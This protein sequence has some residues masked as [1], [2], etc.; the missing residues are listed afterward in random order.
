MKIKST[1]I[2]IL[3]LF[4]LYIKGQ[5][6]LLFH[7][8]FDQPSGPDSVTTITIS[9]TNP[10]LWN[11][12][13]FLFSSP[14]R[15]YHVKGS[16]NSSQVVFQTSAF[17]TI[18]Q[19][20][21]YLKF[22]HIAKLFAV[23]KGR[24]SISVDSG[25]TWTNLTPTNY[26]G[27][28]LFPYH[29]Y[30]SA[31]SYGG[32]NYGDPWN[33][34]VYSGAGSIPN[35]SWWREE[36]FDIT[37]KAL[38]WTN[39]GYPDVMIRFTA[40]F[41]LPE[42]T[43]NSYQ[44]GWYIDDL[45][46]TGSQCELIPPTI[47]Q[48]PHLNCWI[49]PL[50]G[51]YVSAHSFS[52]A[53]KFNATDNHQIDSLRLVEIINGV[54]RF[55]SLSYYS[56]FNY[57]ANFSGYSAFDTVKYRVE[58]YD[59]CGNV[60][61]FPDTGYY[62]F[63]FGE[64]FPK[65]VGGNCGTNHNFINSFPWTQDFEDSVWI[66]SSATPWT[67]RGDFPNYLSYEVVPVEF[68]SFGWS[69]ISG[70][71]PILESGPASDHTTGS[72]KYLYSNFSGQTSASNTTFVLP[73][74]DVRD[75]V[76]RY[77]SF[78]YHMYG[79]DIR[80]IIVQIDSTT[81][82]YQNWHRVWDRFYQQQPSEYAPWKK[83]VVDL[84]PYQGKMIK[85]K[86]IAIIDVNNQNRGNIAIDDLFIGDLPNQDIATTTLLNPNLESI[87]CYG[88]NG[89]VVKGNFVN[90]SQAPIS[91]IPVAY[92]LDNNPA[93]Y[94][95]IDFS[96]V[97]VG[98]DTNFAFNTPLNISPTVSHTL[99][100]W[101]DL[102]GDVNNSN[103]T[104]TLEIPIQKYFSIN[105]FPHFL[106]FEGDTAAFD[107]PGVLNS[108]HWSLS[109]TD[110]NIFW[111][112]NHG[113]FLNDP[114][115]PLNISGRND[116][117]LVFRGKQNI[118]ALQYVELLSQCVD[119]TG[120]VNPVLQFQYHNASTSN[121]IEVLVKEPEDGVWTSLN[122]YPSPTS[123]KTNSTGIS[124]NL[125][126][127]TGKIV[128][129]KI[130]V[131]NN[132]ATYSVAMLD[133][134]IIRESPTVDLELTKAGLTSIEEGATSIP[135]I[136]CFITN[137]SKNNSSSLSTVLKMELRKTCDTGNT[138]I[139][140]Q[141]L[142]AT[143]LP[144]G[145]NVNVQMANMTLST[146]MIPGNYSAKFWLETASDSF[147]YNDTIYKD[148]VCLGKIELPYYN[149]FEDCFADVNAYGKY[150]QWQVA[151]PSKAIID[152][153]YEGN[154]CMITNAEMNLITPNG[155]YNYFELPPFDG[156]DTL[157]GVKLSFWQNFD[158]A[159]YQGFGSVEIY[160]GQNWQ[161]LSNGKAYGTNWKSYIAPTPAGNSQ[162]PYGFVG[163]SN[164]WIH[165][166]YPLHEFMS[167]GKKTIRFVCSANDAEGWAIDSIA[168][169]RP[170][171][172]S[173]SPQEV[174]A[175][176]NVISQGSNNVQIKVKN[177]ARAPLH[178]V[179]ITIE[180]NGNLIHNEVINL[181]SPILAGKSAILP[182]SQP[183]VLNPSM[184]E[185]LVYTSN[186]NSRKDE[187]KTDDTLLVPMHLLAETDSLPVCY[188]F[189]QNIDFVPFN[190]SSGLINSGWEKGTPSKITLTNAH[191]GNNAWYTS[192]NDYE[193]LL[194]TFL[195]T[196]QLP[197]LAGKCYR[198]GFW[199]QFDTELN[200]DGGIVEFTLDSGATWYTLGKYWSTDSLWYN[201]QYVQSLDGFKP[202]W[203]GQS[204]DW[205][206]A[207]QE[208]NAFDDGHIQFRFRFSSNATISGEG[209]A[210]DDVCL[211]PITG[212]CQT[213]SLDEM[214]QSSSLISLYP[215]PSKD[216]L[217][218]LT[219]FDETLAVSIFDVKAGMVK[220]WTQKFE[221]G[222][223]ISIRIDDLPPG[224][225]WISIQH[226]DNPIMKKFIKM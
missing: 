172:N 198:L 221:K 13:S 128:Q 199:H 98:F 131:K 163:S 5:T 83:A 137:W 178:Q 193:E 174:L 201:T 40:E 70:S 147:A 184:S 55:S 189:E 21:V 129:F 99:K 153:A 77:F 20:A 206:Y 212:S 209:W 183:L 34:Y 110:T 18:G 96:G 11:D 207:E 197:I 217:H 133:N 3:V 169:S 154:R 120:L 102:N 78:Y 171:Q 53:L 27:S 12:T 7:E 195:Y 165:S 41:T 23:N 103:D 127:Y 143:N 104:V 124:Y 204:D 6:T 39:S 158:F 76:A 66:P 164:G 71:T 45:E 87:A 220:S 185:L 188:D 69:I 114:Q 37:S 49:G 60:S 125:S 138:I 84:S 17:S 46:V 38:G 186:P 179:E 126:P 74:I 54:P 152:S 28:S 141:T 101:S 160:D 132:G 219:P 47:T 65:C 79:S 92:K 213:I 82:I 50:Q 190:A 115:G 16:V 67:I 91:K 80:R 44:S 117:C 51:G 214:T 192:N 156:L 64:S 222:K 14:G 25:A 97:S 36:A 218:L 145:L 68:Q 180:S 139:T 149:N 48:A 168:I 75:S 159:G 150:A 144:T 216:M 72:G 136:K 215:I 19:K 146:A 88:S 112:I 81:S 134:L 52:A 135:S 116:Q 194:N 118:P 177:T 108:I 176:K 203:T 224:I 148:I 211:E 86:I 121:F 210:I 175:N 10:T 63:Y 200:F 4:T 106:D 100:V 182:L 93:V 43:S 202:G 29:G 166:S 122:A 26:I 1:A 89:I 119:F 109:S 155:T 191:Q 73:C 56:S 30:F 142:A 157:Y 151:T 208:F 111:E 173:A 62:K 61:S 196:P 225:Y 123:P 9:G 24:V 130:R 226:P 140:G 22:N 32:V 107:T 187:I 85:L 15:S 162:Y 223:E 161:S 2:L 181:Q 205:I 57:L 95:T 8:N 90:Q 105:T 42:P 58:A 94:D 167:S 59:T 113:P 170:K 31:V 33:A 35:N